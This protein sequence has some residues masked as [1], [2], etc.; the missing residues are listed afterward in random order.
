MTDVPSNLIPTRIT[1]LPEYEGDSTEGYAPY[2]VEG[3]TY[4]AKLANIVAPLADDVA[5][6]AAAAEAARDA[7][8]AYKFQTEALVQDGADS[9]LLAQA[10]AEGTLPG[11]A[12]T[13]SAKEWSEVSEASADTATAARD[14]A[15][16]AVGVDYPD[17]AAA[18]SGAVNGDRFTYWDGDQIVFAKK[19]AGAISPLPGPWIGADKISTPSGTV[20]DDIASLTD[21]VALLQESLPVADL[22]IQYSGTSNQVALVGKSIRENSIVWHPDQGKY[23]LLADV[24]DTSDPV[25]PNTYGTE[26]HLLSSADLKTWTYHGVAIEKGGVGEIGEFGVATPAGAAYFGGKIYCPF[27]ARNTSGWTNRNIG[28]AWSGSDP[29]ILPWTRADEAVANTSGEDDDPAVVAVGDTLHLYFRTTGSATVSGYHIAHA[30]SSTPEDVG[31]W[32]TPVACT[33]NP[34]PG[35]RAQELTAAFLYGGK[36]HLFVMEQGGSESGTA[37]LAS[38]N[39]ADPDFP[40]FDLSVRMVSPPTTVAY[41]GHFTAVIGADGEPAAYTWTVFVDSYTGAATRYGLDLRMAI[42]SRSIAING[43]SNSPALDGAST[44]YYTVANSSSAQFA[45]GFT[46]AAKVTALTDLSTEQVIFQRG[47]DGV[48]GSIKIAL[49]AA[50][51]GIRVDVVKTGN[52]L[53]TFVPA[54]DVT[55]VLTSGNPFCVVFTRTSAGVATLYLIADGALSTLASAALSYANF[56]ISGSFTAGIGASYSGGSASAQFTGFIHELALWNRGLSAADARAFAGTSVAPSD[57][58]TPAGVGEFAGCRSHYVFSG[59]TGNDVSDLSGYGRSAI[60]AGTTAKVTAPLSIGAGAVMTRDAVQ[61]IPDSTWTAVS[62][63][64]QTKVVGGLWDGTYFRAPSSGWYIVTGSI[65]FA[66]NATGMRAARVYKGASIYSTVVNAEA[67]AIAG[68]VSVHSFSTLVYLDK[69]ET[70]SLQVYQ[71]SG[72]ALNIETANGVPLM[73]VARL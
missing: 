64:T 7:A 23:Y 70:V 51:N 66:S 42:R 40:Q 22:V 28:L 46:V 27:S 21:K 62:F 56:A 11:G 44:S 36:V 60:F 50:D 67:V 72:G 8:L 31:S 54:Q 5:I 37:H 4:K 53:Q 3:R 68:Q 15:Q 35:V 55:E 18:L 58:Y 6:A 69:G 19:E 17:A 65:R 71:T 57:R 32:S 49:N 41:N 30:A 61:S 63:N 34:E 26:I 14:V 39:P 25:H 24:V 20:A 10:W 47:T 29:E 13:K 16:A 59:V 38:S 48:A 12:G 73:G 1:Q 9:A 43:A 45:G 2:A 33:V 52:V